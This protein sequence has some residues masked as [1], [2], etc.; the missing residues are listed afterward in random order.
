MRAT[1]QGRGDLGSGGGSV[2]VAEEPAQEPLAAN[3]T[4]ANG[5]IVEPCG[6]FN[7]ALLAASD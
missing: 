6:S 5:I 7:V 3:V 2:V 1:D 4:C